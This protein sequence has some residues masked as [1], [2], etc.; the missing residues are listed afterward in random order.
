MI[1]LRCGHCC[2]SYV[3]GIVDDPEKGPVEGNI[4]A[5]AGEGPCKHL[6]GDKPGSYSCAL[7]DYPW[8]PETPC[9]AH[10]QIEG[11]NTPCRLGRYLLERGGK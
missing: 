9:Y 8:Y 5:H 2:K 4:I 10:G 11:R 3:V 1:C 7:H 6:R